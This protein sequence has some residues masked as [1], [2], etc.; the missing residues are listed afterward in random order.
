MVIL[1]TRFY[2]GDVDQQWLVGLAPRGVAAGGQRS[3]G[4]AMVALAPGDEAAARRLADLEAILPGQLHRGLVGLRTTGQ[5]VHLTDALGGPGHQ[6]LGQGLGGLVGE[7]AGVRKG[8][9]PD[10]LD[11]GLDH[12]RMGVAEAGHRRS[13]R[14]VE[15]AFTAAVDQVG[16]FAGDGQ[17]RCLLRVTMQDVR[18]ARFL[19]GGPGI[20]HGAPGRSLPGSIG[21][22][23]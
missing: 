14:G 16:P 10:L 12:R 5:E 20:R 9:A 23:L 21:S 2:M 4:V 8:Q 13:A 17:G 18:H 1:E 7:K 15:V 19:R 11:H 22:R 3:Q 6:M